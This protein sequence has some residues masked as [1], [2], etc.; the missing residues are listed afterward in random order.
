[1]PLS[2]FRGG[3]KEGPVKRLFSEGKRLSGEGENET[4]KMPAVQDEER[5]VKMRRGPEVYKERLLIYAR[6][7]KKVESCR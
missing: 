5:F 2:A 3:I 7:L 4:Q 1:M 6:R